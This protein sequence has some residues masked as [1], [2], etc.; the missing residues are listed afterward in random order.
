M[1]TRFKQA[2]VF[3]GVVAALFVSSV[4]CAQ[5]AG[6]TAE[7]KTRPG[8]EVI[9]KLIEELGLTSEQ[10]EK[11]RKQRSEDRKVNQEIGKELRDKK[12][13]LKGELEKEEVDKGRI[14]ILVEEIKVLLGKQL[15]Q[16]V[17][18]I[19]STKEILTPEQ[20]KEFQKKVGYLAKTRR[21]H[22][23]SRL[24]GGLGRGGRQTERDS[25]E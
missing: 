23:K 25:L 24:K 4:V 22:M 14:D 16:R 7:G 13:V 5:S 9:Q 12:V 17:Q 10:Q 15:E 6:N 3:T 11:L 18:R 1:N 21:Q 19:F 8:R 2:V 20:F